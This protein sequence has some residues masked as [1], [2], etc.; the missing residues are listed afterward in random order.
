[1]NVHDV[2]DHEGNLG[3]GSKNLSMKDL[4]KKAMDKI[5]TLQ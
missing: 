1:M 2:D 4:Y 3:M 5:P